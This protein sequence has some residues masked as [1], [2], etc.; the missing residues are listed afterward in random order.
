MQKTSVSAKKKKSPKLFFCPNIS[1]L[2]N[3][4]LFFCMLLGDLPF[5]IKGVKFSQFL[6]GE[7]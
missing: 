3:I 6:C 5:I 2:E 7:K 4:F 1:S